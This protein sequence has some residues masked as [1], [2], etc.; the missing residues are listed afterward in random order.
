MKYLINGL[1][2]LANK[3]EK[4]KCSIHFKWNALLE[5]L[6]TNCICEKSEK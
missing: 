3:L 6:K 2:Y 5:N 4:L 1:R